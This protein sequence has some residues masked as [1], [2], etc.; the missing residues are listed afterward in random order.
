MPNSR[1][2]IK[3]ILEGFHNIETGRLSFVNETVTELISKEILAHLKTVSGEDYLI[4]VDVGYADALIFM[5][6]LL[7]ETARRLGIDFQSLRYDIYR[8]YFQGNP[9]PLSAI[10]KA[11]GRGTLKILSN[12]SISERNPEALKELANKFGLNAENYYQKAIQ[13][14]RNKEV[15]ILDGV[16]IKQAIVAK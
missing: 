10:D 6:M 4:G 3:G 2:K 5:D 12:L 11:F 1:L 7:K 9:K 16:K 14:A 13:L 15:E 8:G